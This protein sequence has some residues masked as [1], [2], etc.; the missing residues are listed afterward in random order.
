MWG[1]IH[2][3]AVD[4]VRWLPTFFNAA[5]LGGAVGLDA[6]LLALLLPFLG[7]HGVMASRNQTT[8]ESGSEA[9]ARFDVGLISN[10][11]QVLGARW[12]T[13]P[14]PAYLYGPDGDGVR[15]PTRDLSTRPP[16]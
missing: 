3:P 1:W 13:W 4:G 16:G 5:C 8:I 9:I 15:W 11:R 10:L 2:S 6:L 12:W 14:I 7:Y